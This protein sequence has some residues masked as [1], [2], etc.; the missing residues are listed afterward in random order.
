[1]KQELSASILQAAIVGLTHKKASL[2]SQ[3][4]AVDDDIAKVRAMLPVPPASPLSHYVKWDGKH[5]K[6]ASG[7]AVDHAEK[8][9]KELGNVSTKVNRRWNEAA[10]KRKSRQMK[11]YWR[12]RKAAAVAIKRIALAHRP[13]KQGRR[14]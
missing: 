6:A 12:E 1:M 7:K 14:G 8:L 4:T 5:W 10:K 13:K 11:A 2:L 3:V 9:I